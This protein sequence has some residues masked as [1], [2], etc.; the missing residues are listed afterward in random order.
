MGGEGGGGEAGGGER[1]TIEIFPGLGS[2]RQLCPHFPGFDSPR[3]RERSASHRAGKPSPQ[4]IRFV[5]VSMGTVWLPALKSPAAWGWKAMR[6]GF[7]AKNRLAQ[8]GR[9]S[10]AGSFAIEEAYFRVNTVPVLP[11]AVWRPGGN[12][13]SVSK[14][15]RASL[16]RTVEGVEEKGRKAWGLPPW[17]TFALLSRGR[18][19]ETVPGRQAGRQ[20]ARRRVVSTG[21]KGGGGAERKGRASGEKEACRTREA[22][23]ASASGALCAEAS[24]ERPG[25]SRVPT[26]ESR[27]LFRRLFPSHPPQYGWKE[28]KGGRGGEGRSLP[29]AAPLPA[30][31]DAQSQSQRGAPPNL[32]LRRAGR[33]TPSWSKAAPLLGGPGQPAALLFGAHPR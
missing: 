11:G 9:S 8:R 17:L 25:L 33:P 22:L 24:T 16:G 23:P 19:G 12:L 5:A 2:W 4:R 28:G 18:A 32:L 3:A 29:P 10:E 21:L 6:G 13:P 30:P 1:E 20:A 15:T 31:R 26:A 7:G 14:E 27:A